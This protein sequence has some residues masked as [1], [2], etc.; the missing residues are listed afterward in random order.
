MKKLPCGANLK[1]DFLRFLKCN[2]FKTTMPNTQHFA[3]LK[4][5]AL[6]PRKITGPNWLLLK[7]KSIV[8]QEIGDWLYYIYLVRTTT[9]KILIQKG[10]SMIFK[11]VHW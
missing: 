9:L 4:K 6:F 10:L 11:I 8:M 5:N 7:L 2:S 1:R 3:I